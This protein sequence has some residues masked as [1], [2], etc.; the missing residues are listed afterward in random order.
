MSGWSTAVPHNATESPNVI[1][2]RLQREVC[3]CCAHVGS[4]S[5]AFQI[6][7]RHCGNTL[8]LSRLIDFAARFYSLD[9]VG[10]CVLPRGPARRWPRHS[11][12]HLEVQQ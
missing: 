3:E 6:E 8:Y 9:H 5:I 2:C 12:S 7:Y 11:R 4:G 1:L 10:R